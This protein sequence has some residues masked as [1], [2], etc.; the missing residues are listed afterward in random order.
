M[1]DPHL[2]FRLYQAAHCSAVCAGD[3]ESAGTYRHRVH[4]IAAEVGEP[5]MRWASRLI[6]GF[7]A[8]MEA[9]F[10]EADSM[11]TEALELGVQSGDPDAFP[12]FLLQYSV[13]GMFAGRHDEL[14]PVAQ[15][16]MES[17]PLLAL[18]FRVAYGILCCEVGRWDEAS[19]LL[20]D[21]IAGRLGPIPHDHT[22]TT[23]LIGLATVAVELDDVTAAEWLYP[24]IAPM[25]DEVSYN[26][27]TSQG[28]I[29]AYAGK[30]EFLLERYD[31]AERH[32][33]DALATADAFGW[34]Y[35]RATTLIGLARNRLRADGAL[36]AE[37]GRWLA[38][39]EELC[40]THGI[41]SW[42]KRTKALRSQ[43][44]AT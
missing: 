26:G 2:A 10:A 36:D 42:T 32:L 19:T 9:R 28:P 35:H 27:V 37:G 31:D 40:V 25:A 16:A 14:F 20:H 6:D 44:A 39:A 18:A 30:L 13:L 29:S 43:L 7:V 23:T 11:V 12:F 3:A 38:T 34:V 21:A 15:Q 1:D 8:M 33:L 41:N 24:R 4:A 17:D 22:R 5:V